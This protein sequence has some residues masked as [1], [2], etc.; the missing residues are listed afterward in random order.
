MGF[1]YLK[2]DRWTQ[3]TRDERFFCQRLYELVKAEP[4]EDFVRYLSE[5]LN[6]NLPI[7]GEWEIGY[8]VVFYRDLWQ[9]R[10]REGKLYSPKRTF[11]LCLF[12]ESAILIIEANAAG[13]FDSNQNEVFKRDI[14]AVRSLTEVENVHLIGLCSSKCTPDKSSESTFGDR[15]IH[16]KDMAKR[17]RNDEIL[18]RADKIYEPSEAFTNRER[19]SDIKLSGTALLEAFHGGA[20]WW[21][22]RGGGGISGERFLEDVRTGC[23][24]TQVYEVNTIADAQPSPNYFGLVDFVQAVEKSSAE[25]KNTESEMGDT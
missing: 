7:T 25:T 17:Y 6:L 21:I 12:G 16:W 23:W 11:D 24:E 4:V 9:H 1:K 13:G 8:E 20:E 14:A 3:V 22:G 10:K 15:L 18:N 19:N 5:S 2:G